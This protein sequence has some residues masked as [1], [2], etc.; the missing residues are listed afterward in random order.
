MNKLLCASI[1]CIIS[2]TALAAETFKSEDA[3]EFR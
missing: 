3:R 2:N 1:I